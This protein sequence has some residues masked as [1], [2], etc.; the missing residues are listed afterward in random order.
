MGLRG[1]GKTVLLNKIEQL[2][3]SHGHLTAFIEAPEDRRLTELLYPRL[4]QV[5]RRLS[6]VDRAKDA[7]HRALRALR[8]FA[9][10]FKVSFGD[11]SIAVDPEPGTADSGILEFDL[12]DLFVRI[13]EAA[14]AAGKAWTL[15]IDEVQYLS[16]EELS[17]L[18][19]AIHRVNQKNL[20]IMFFG[21]GLPQ[22]AA[23]SGDAKSYAE[24]L[25]SYPTIGPLDTRSAKSA[26]RQPIEVEGEAILDDALEAIM[27]RTQRYPYFLQEWG[28]QVWNLAEKSPIDRND[29]KAAT[30]A[31]IRRLD[32]GFFACGLIDLRQRNGN[33]CSPWQASVPAP[34]A[35]PMSQPVWER[36]SRHLVLAGQQ[37]FARE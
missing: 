5:L 19:V 21:A 27:D 22:V 29:V 15:L 7:T 6:L 17:A 30:E 35:Q 16:D 8:S 31:A 1:T 25:F 34:I 12:G 32:E 33:M 13:G 28:F 20:P 9:A 23:L 18:I 11:F 10:A 26:I 4:H 37:S 3:E 36:R 2:A 24:R 14:Q